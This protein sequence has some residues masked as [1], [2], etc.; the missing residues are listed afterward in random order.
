MP[1]LNAPLNRRSFLKSSSLAA[2]TAFAGPSLM[3]RSFASAGA[4][5]PGGAGGG[6]RATVI[7]NLAGGADTHAFIVPR[8]AEHAAY[9][10]A[11]GPLS[12]PVAELLPLPVAGTGGVPLGMHSRLGSLKSM[13]DQG[14]LAIL[15]NV[16]SLVEPVNSVQLQAG[17]RQIPMHLY[18]HNKQA[19]C[20]QQG[21]SDRDDAFGWA[22]LA[23]DRLSAANAPDA[24]CN[25]SLGQVKRLHIGR[26]T[27]SYTV[28]AAGAAAYLGLNSNTRRAAFQALLARGDQ[29]SAFLREYARIQSGSIRQH[30]IVASALAQSPPVTTVFPPPTGPFQQFDLPG[31][32]RMVARLISARQAL[33]ATRQIFYVEMGGWDSHDDPALSNVRDGMSALDGA[34]AAFHAALGELGVRDR[35]TTA[36]VSEFGR[37]LT[38]NGRGSDHGWG[39]HYMVF[40]DSVI[41]GRLHG[42]FPDLALGSLRD[43]G[44]GRL[45]PTTSFDQ[46]TATLMEW[47]GLIPNELAEMYPTLVNFPLSNM[48]FMA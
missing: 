20:W 13:Y 27:T 14:T 9:A 41:G 16:G 18:A 26:A 12:V 35:V 19:D 47:M 39:G 45:I 3:V 1:D 25:V 5:P 29:E 34:L 33:Q 32:L 8:G 42:D 21:R 48:G 6:Y 28:R 22:G 4:H 40:G 36:L 24:P 31:Q 23:A 7:V 38:S 46:Y 43:A 11:R 17:L 10:A 30:A 37:T 15:P 2:A 44:A